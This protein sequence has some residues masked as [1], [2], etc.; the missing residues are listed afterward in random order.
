MLCQWPQWGT[1]GGLPASAWN[2]LTGRMTDGTEVD[3]TFPPVGCKQAGRSVQCTQ[4]PACPPR[5]WSQLQG[6]GWAEGAQS[7]DQSLHH[8]ALAHC[9]A[10]PAVPGSLHPHPGGQSRL[11]RHI[12]SQLPSLPGVGRHW[13]GRSHRTLPRS[14]AAHVKRHVQA[15]PASV[16][17]C[18]QFRRRHCT[19]EAFLSGQVLWLNTFPQDCLL[20]LGPAHAPTTKDQDVPTALTVMSPIEE[21]KASSNLIV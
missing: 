12:P 11:G 9:L 8:L 21:P 13:Y 20:V 16:S 18:E 17:C 6:A 15:H 3:W 7:R 1:S 5:R 2:G 19:Q 4:V 10:Y 14:L